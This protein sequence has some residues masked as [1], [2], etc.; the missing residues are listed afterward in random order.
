MRLIQ[1]RRLALALASQKLARAAT[2]ALW[3]QRLTWFGAGVS[4]GVAAW[5][6]GEVALGPI[7]GSHPSPPPRPVS[8]PLRI[9]VDGAVA[10]PGVY[11]LPPGARVEDA[12]RAAGGVAERG[13][14]SELNLV[15]RLTD[16]QRVLVPARPP[17]ASGA[18]PTP[19][20]PRPFRTP[21]AGPVAGSASQR[22]PPDAANGS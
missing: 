15:A 2:R 10:R 3:L 11:E 21:T 5:L 16:G 6:A 17:P 20:R 7:V 4:T 9:Q 13:D 18:T 22:S 12:L 1:G 19:L 8:P 14:S